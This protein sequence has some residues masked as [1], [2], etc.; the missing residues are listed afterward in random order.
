M[1]KKISIITL[2]AIIGLS[3]VYAQKNKN[4]II[5]PPA[6]DSLYETV[7]IKKMVNPVF[8]NDYAN[9]WVHFKTGFAITMASL[10][11]LPKE[12]QKDYVRII[13]M[14]TADLSFT[15]IVPKSKSDIVFDLKAMDPIEIFGYS[16]LVKYTD[17]TQGLIIKVEKIVRATK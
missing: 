14:E 6:N 1:K 17:G 13:T 12:Y 9:K 3:S 5:A 16:N 8:F 2:L 11:D 15:I 7:P 10:E 4:T